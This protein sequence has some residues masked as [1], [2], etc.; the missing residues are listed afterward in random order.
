MLYTVLRVIIRWLLLVWRRWQVK[1]TEHIPAGGG[2]V[3]VAN[4]VSNLD[5]VVL[6]CALTRRIHFMAKVQL[7]KVPVL[8]T[9][10]TMLGAFPV[11]RDKTDRHA[12]RRALE[13]LQGGHMVG[14]FP[15]GT[16]SKTGDLQKPHIGAAMLAVK[17]DVPILPVS[18]QGTRGIFNKITVNIGEPIYLP[19]LWRGKPG[20]AELEELSQQ[21]M[22][23]IKNLMK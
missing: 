13:L 15:E 3:V 18:L 17:A 8:S 11:N 4:H 6:G 9:V 23:R 10:I 16:R 7:F 12:V 1:G 5:P 21:L 19:E 14:I 20:K 2:V 22:D